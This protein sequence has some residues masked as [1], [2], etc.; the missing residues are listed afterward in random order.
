MG[1]FPPAGRAPQQRPA[2]RSTRRSRC[3]CW[4]PGSALP[5]AALRGVGALRSSPRSTGSCWSSI[6]S[7]RPG[8]ENQRLHQRVTELE[9]ENLRLRE[10]GDREPPAAPPARAADLA[11]SL[12][13]KPVEVLLALGRADPDRRHAQR[14][15]RQGV[16]VGDAVVT[17]DGLLGAR[18]RGLSHALPRGAALRSPTRRSPAR[19]RAPAC[20]ACSTPSPFRARGSCSPACRWRTPCAS[21]SAS[22]TSGLSRRYPRGHPGRGRAPHRP[23][24]HRADAGSRGRARGREALA[25]PACVRH[26]PARRR[27][28]SSMRGVGGG[29]ASSSS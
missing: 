14:R 23:R 12:P 29:P 1:G 3:F 19:S 9:L 24:S 6:A 28:R 27:S 20:S 2:R 17:R 21:G 22:S 26:H 13:L 18:R 5:T 16:E 10:R 8:R 4:P 15:R 25:H 7:P 11:R